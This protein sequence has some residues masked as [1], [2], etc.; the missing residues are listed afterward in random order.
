MA[1]DIKPEYDI[2]HPN[3]ELK[4]LEKAEKDARKELVRIEEALVAV[5]EAPKH[6]IEIALL[7]ANDERVSLSGT[8]GKKYDVMRFPDVSGKNVKSV[9][10]NAGIGLMSVLPD[11]EN[12]RVRLG[13]ER[14]RVQAQLRSYSERTARA[15]NLIEAMAKRARGDS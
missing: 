3:A 14:N 15:K 2:V 7:D 10:T 8:D 6:T 9:L 13:G 12:L 4:M 11:E 5:A 1:G